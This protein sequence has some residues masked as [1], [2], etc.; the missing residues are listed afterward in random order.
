M[1]RKFMVFTALFTLLSSLF[2]FKSPEVKAKRIVV[3]VQ[4]IA[5]EEWRERYG[6]DWKSRVW[7]MVENADEAFYD[8]FKIDFSPDYCVAWDL[9]DSITDLSDLLAAADSDV[10]DKGD[11][12]MVFS[13][14]LSSG[15]A[16][17]T[18]YAGA[19]EMI[20]RDTQNQ[21]YDWDTTRHEASHGYYCSH[22]GHSDTTTD[23]ILNQN[24]SV[25]DT[26]CWD[27][28]NSHKKKLQ[29]NNHATK[30]FDLCSSK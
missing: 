4:T 19:D 20:V 18:T 8:E 9:D 3:S 12:K 13:S 6:K 23:C 5:D 29:R 27:T 30:V 15:D 25:W 21:S 22:R 10:A 24:S 28:I 16:G 1:K 2:F 26:N 17:V 14:Q 11:F 7:Y